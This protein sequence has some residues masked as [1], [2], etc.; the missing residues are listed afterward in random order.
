MP[1]KPLNTHHLGDPGLQQIRQP[2]L[3]WQTNF[4]ALFGLPNGPPKITSIGDAV[5]M[6]QL[7]TRRVTHHQKQRAKMPK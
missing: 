4:E 6:Y 1:H 5:A 2:I 7:N 3:L